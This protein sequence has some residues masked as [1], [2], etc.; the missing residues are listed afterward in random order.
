MS[1]EHF[2]SIQVFSQTHV[3]AQIACSAESTFFCEIDI[4]S[5]IYTFD[6]FRL[7]GSFSSVF[8]NWTFK[9][10]VEDTTIAGTETSWY[11][12]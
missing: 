12:Q 10:T 6:I 4:F 9:G 8:V 5:F 1:E 7:T 11:Y 3:S 2:P